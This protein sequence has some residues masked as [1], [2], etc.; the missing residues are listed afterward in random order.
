ML[1]S[2]Y[3]E[4]ISSE[5][6]LLREG[7][8]LT[9]GINGRVPPDLNIWASETSSSFLQNGSL[10][11][12]QQPPTERTLAPTEQLWTQQ[13]KK[14]GLFRSSGV[15]GGVHKVTTGWSSVSPSSMPGLDKGQPILL[16]HSFANSTC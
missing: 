1:A 14:E 12:R 10:H 2:G 7:K 13:H 6:G 15:I 5:T 4:D 11:N 3:L 8:Q 16:N 9:K